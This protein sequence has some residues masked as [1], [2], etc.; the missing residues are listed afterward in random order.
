M[1]K[2]GSLVNN[3]NSEVRLKVVHAVA[4]MFH[5]PVNQVSIS[6]KRF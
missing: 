6:L 2:M 4:E 1:K 3:S 5:I